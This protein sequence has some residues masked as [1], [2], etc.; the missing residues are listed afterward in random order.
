MPSAKVTLTPKIRSPLDWYCY[1]KQRS[2]M[3]MLDYNR[4]GTSRDLD[5]MA[6]AIE[7]FTDSQANIRLIVGKRWTGR[8]PVGIG[9]MS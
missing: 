3:A 9:R 1:E 6:K 7:R 8:V 5:E 4:A 2:Q